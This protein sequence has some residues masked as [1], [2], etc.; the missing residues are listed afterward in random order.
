MVKTTKTAVEPAKSLAGAKSR[1]VPWMDVAR[2]VRHGMQEASLTQGAQEVARFQNA[3]AAVSGYSVGA[4]KRFVARLQFL[5]GLP[6]GHRPPPEIA[7]S[8]FTAIEIIERICKHDVQKGRDLLLKLNKGKKIVVS[9]FR[10]ILNDLRKSATQ[11]TSGPVVMAYHHSFAAVERHSRK[12]EAFD[13]SG[14][15]CHRSAVI[16]FYSTGH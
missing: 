4:L 11:V 13:K 12:A 16:S 14:N 9:E 7:N 3:A 6:D 5:D 15:Y 2:S 10:K 1:H 8:A